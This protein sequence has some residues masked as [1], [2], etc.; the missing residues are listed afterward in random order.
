LTSLCNRKCWPLPACFFGLDSFFVSNSSQFVM[1]LWD[2]LPITM[3]SGNASYIKDN[4]V[5][6]HRRT[7]RPSCFNGKTHLMHNSFISRSF[8]TRLVAIVTVSSSLLSSCNPPLRRWAREVGC[9]W[10]KF[11]HCQSVGWLVGSKKKLRDVLRSFSTRGDNFS[12]HS[13]LL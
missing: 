9:K 10:G 7:C 11:H 13:S 3:I 1:L 6:S 5:Q 12:K 2:P 8:F 4:I